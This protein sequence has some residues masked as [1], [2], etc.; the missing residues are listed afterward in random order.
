MKIRT[1]FVTNSSSSSFT[2]LQIHSS[3]LE[4]W[5]KKKGEYSLAEYCDALTSKIDWEYS[6]MLD[7]EFS[8]FLENGVT[9]T[10]LLLYLMEAGEEEMSELTQYLQ[11]KQEEID[12]QACA[13]FYCTYVGQGEGPELHRVVIKNGVAELDYC[14]TDDG[15]IDE[16]TLLEINS[17]FYECID[18][19]TP[20][21]ID[22][23][24]ALLNDEESEE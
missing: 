14:H 20:E 13:R 6:H 23:I 4:N 9:I 8:E 17:D 19:N 15:E 3:T 12:N 24:F 22:Q 11:E 21:I 18:S 10:N 7:D 2:V 16:D 5:F 1:D